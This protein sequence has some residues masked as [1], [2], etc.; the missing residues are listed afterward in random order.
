[1]DSETMAHCFDKFWQADPSGTRRY[2]GTGIGLYIVRSLVEAM[3]GEISVRSELQRG[4]T[5]VL[6]F[7]AAAPEKA[8]SANDPLRLHR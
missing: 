3:G 4:S 8:G 1:M 6:R 5:F 2:G 7:M